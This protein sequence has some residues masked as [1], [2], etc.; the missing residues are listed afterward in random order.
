MMQRQP[1]FMTKRAAERSVSHS[2]AGH[3]SRFRINVLS[4]GEV[5][6]FRESKVDKVH[7]LQNAMGKL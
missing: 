4:I 5:E 6:F 3:Q 2:T 1:R 7:C